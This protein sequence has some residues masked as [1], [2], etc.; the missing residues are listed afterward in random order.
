MTHVPVHHDASRIAFTVSRSE[1]DWQISDDLS[2][3]LTLPGATAPPEV[4][5]ALTTA[6][7]ERV[8]LLTTAALV[9]GVIVSKNDFALA[10]VGDDWGSCT[11]I[12]LHLSLRGW[13]IVTPRYAFVDNDTR[14]VEPFSKLLYIPSRIIPLLPLDYRRALEASPWYST[15]NE[16][17]FYGVDPM[18]S[19]RPA[20]RS[21]NIT[22]RASLIVDSSRRDLLGSVHEPAHAYVGSFLPFSDIGI[23]SA[24]LVVGAI[25]STTDAVER[26]ADSL[27]AS[28]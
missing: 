20:A 16:L 21:T 6:M 18:R 24:S 10:L 12:A 27:L 15:G 7:V 5:G 22:L 13:S 4:A 28:V 25:V 14:S 8:A 3:I 1:D 17:G 2:V 26:W 11:A 9:T 19:Q 23:A